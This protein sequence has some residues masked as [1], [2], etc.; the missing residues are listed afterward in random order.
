METITKELPVQVVA[1]LWITGPFLLLSGFST[2][3]PSLL[4]LLPLLPLMCLFQ[5]FELNFL[6]HHPLVH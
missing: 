1:L 3:L 6:C 2:F 4:H 5:G